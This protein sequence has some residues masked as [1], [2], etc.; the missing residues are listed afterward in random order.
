MLPRDLEDRVCLEDLASINSVAYGYTTPAAKFLA[1]SQAESKPI[2]PH[3][4]PLSQNKPN[5]HRKKK[6]TAQDQP[7]NKA[8]IVELL[9]DLVAEKTPAEKPIEKPT[10]IQ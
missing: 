4:K 1:T 6:P 2:E 7:T 9:K 3:L 10:K 5:L 8:A